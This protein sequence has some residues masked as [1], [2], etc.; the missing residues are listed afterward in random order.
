VRL[1]DAD[2]EWLYH[3]VP[4]GTRVYIY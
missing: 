3:N 1:E 4:V 2:L